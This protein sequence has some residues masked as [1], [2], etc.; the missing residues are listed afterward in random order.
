MRDSYNTDLFKDIPS[1][2]TFQ[3]PKNLY[4]TLDERGHERA[5]STYGEQVR[6]LGV[7]DQEPIHDQL[8]AIYKY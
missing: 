4:S 2:T 8:T 7:N 1:L 3:C 5:G 6:I